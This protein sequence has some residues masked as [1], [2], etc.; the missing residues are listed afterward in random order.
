MKLLPGKQLF[1]PPGPHPYPRAR[2]TFDAMEEWDMPDG[3]RVLVTTHTTGPDE[4]QA[5]TRGATDLRESVV[6]AG[7]LGG[8]ALLRQYRVTAVWN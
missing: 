2:T 8:T 1:A 7:C 6:P 4:F 5:G 3:R